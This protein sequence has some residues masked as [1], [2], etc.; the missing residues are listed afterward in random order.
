[1]TPSQQRIK[2]LA[3][4]L[5]IALT[6]A[7]IWGVA[8]FVFV[9]TGGVSLINNQLAEKGEGQSY[10]LT[11]P[12]EFS[13]DIE[14]AVLNIVSGDTFSVVT[15]DASVRVTEKNGK[16]RINEEGKLI[17]D[18]DESVITLTVPEGYTADKFRLSTGAGAVKVQSLMCDSLVIEV[19]A[20]VAELEY[21]KVNDKAEIEVGTGEIDIR[22]SDIKNLNLDVGLGEG[23]VVGTFTG[24]TEAEVGIG[25]LTLVASPSIDSYTVDAESGIG[26][27]IVNG[28]KINGEKIIGNGANLLEVS[29]GIGKVEVI[30]EQ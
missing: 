2:K 30:F 1:M 16:V 21:L 5:A 25:K 18:L 27:F 29:G 19:G 9:V 10:I 22:S 24:K 13:I 8:C 4:L 26:E 23:E 15:N 6:V 12:K 14:A 20:G 7:I 28:E 17:S 11:N 3:Q